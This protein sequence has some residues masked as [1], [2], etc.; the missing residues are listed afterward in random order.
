MQNFGSKSLKKQELTLSTA[1]ILAQ[2]KTRSGLS[3]LAELCSNFST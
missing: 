2:M 1:K 3:S